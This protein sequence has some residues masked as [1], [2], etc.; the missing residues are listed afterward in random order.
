MHVCR[1]KHFG[2]LAN[3]LIPF[4]LTIDE[5]PRPGSLRWYH[6]IDSWVNKFQDGSFDLQGKYN[7]PQLDIPNCIAEVLSSTAPTPCSCNALPFLRPAAPLSLPSSLALSPPPSFAV[8]IIS[9]FPNTTAVV[10]SL[11]SITHSNSLAQA[12]LPRAL[13]LPMSRLL[14]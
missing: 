1:K 13:P 7:P 10:V 6:V 11:L 14:L 9:R 2:D 5:N 4:Q 12:K 8:R 3:N